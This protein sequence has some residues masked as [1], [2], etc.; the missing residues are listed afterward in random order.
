MAFL[1]WKALLLY[2]L[3]FLDNDVKTCQQNHCGNR[4]CE[5]NMHPQ[6]AMT[7]QLGQDVE[8]EHDLQSHHSN[9]FKRFRPLLATDLAAH[10]SPQ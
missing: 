10:L 9:K 4:L 7:T 1:T 8:G 6:A 5:Q 2:E 3:L